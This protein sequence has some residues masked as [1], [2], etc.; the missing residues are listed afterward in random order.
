MTD[1]RGRSDAPD[2]SDGDDDEV[3]RILSPVR[4]SESEAI[5]HFAAGIASARDAE[6][7]VGHL[8]VEESAFSVDSSRDAA[9]T[10]LQARDDPVVD[11]DLQ[12]RSLQGPSHLEALTTAVAT[13][14]PE[15]VVLGHEMAEELESELARRVDCDTVVVNEKTPLESISS[16]LVPV[17]GGPHAEATV[18]VAGDVAA[19]NDAAVELLHVTDPSPSA[20]ERESA[21]SMLDELGDTLPADVAVETRVVDADDVVERIVEEASGH[22]VPVIGA[23]TKGRL[24]RFVFGSN[25]VSITENA[26]N[27]VAMVREN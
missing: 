4:G 3:R 5:L 16:I 26:P 19:A 23:P 15:L 24:R 25:A 6:L 12:S 8:A 18:D 11:V 20:D 21:R 13:Y 22:D 7:V 10:R 17:A 14:Q 9:L 1:P 27:T 2:R